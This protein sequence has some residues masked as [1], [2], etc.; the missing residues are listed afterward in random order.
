MIIHRHAAIAAVRA[1]GKIDR[2]CAGAEVGRHGLPLLAAHRIGDGHHGAK[3]QSAQDALGRHL[4]QGRFGGTAIARLIVA[5]CATLLIYGFAG[6]FR[7]AL[8][9]QGRC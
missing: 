5:A 1:R 8:S 9:Q 2:R 3:V 6:W 4:V 7:R